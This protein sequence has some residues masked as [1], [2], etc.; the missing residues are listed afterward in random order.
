MWIRGRAADAGTGGLGGEPF[1]ESLL[2]LG[3]QMVTD[4]AG[5]LTCLV[6]TAT[7]IGG[8]L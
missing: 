2:F 1:G 8:F 3:R 6:G 5:E 7:G 4:P